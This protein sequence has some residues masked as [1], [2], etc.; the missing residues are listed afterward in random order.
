M[1]A[2]QQ[3]KRGALRTRS[4]PKPEK[5]T[6]GR[7][8][9]AALL[10]AG[11]L[12]LSAC[13][14]SG[15]VTALA[16]DYNRAIA[17]ARSEQVLLNVLR[18]SAREPLQFTAIS[19]IS[20]TVNRSLGLG[21]VAANLIAGGPDAVSSSLSLGLS[22]NP[23]VRIAPLSS[24]EF[25]EGFLRPITP[26]ALYHFIS[27]GWDGEFLLPLV[28][29][30]YTCNGRRMVNAGD[31]AEGARIRDRLAAAGDTL[32]LR[33]RRTEGA[34]IAMTVSSDRAMEMLSTGAAPGHTVLGVTPATQPGTS[35]VRVRQPD[36]LS[37]VASSAG[38]CDGPADAEAGFEPGVGVTIQLRSPHGIIYFLGEAFRPCFL[39]RRANCDLTYHKDGGLRHMFRIGTQAPPPQGA[40][41]EV[42]FNGTRH[43]IPRLDA[44][45]TDRTLKAVAFLDQLIALQT[46]PGAVTVTPTVI[47]IPAG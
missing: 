28:V 35:V 32:Q 5:R 46:N 13:S 2:W 7:S 41:V 20:A 47:S 43:W 30:S 42:T 6:S 45:D 37:W 12:V 18:A 29:G 40:A 1:I 15:T 11:A 27:Q 44:D 26:E 39:G 3:V 34:V 8:A 9:A 17:H 31:S 19:E 4:R 38:L 22:N 21:S 23:F 25:T 33:Q 10:G 36:A 14:H 16:T 24:Q